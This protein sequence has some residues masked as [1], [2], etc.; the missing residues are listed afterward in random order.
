MS[1][2]RIDRLPPK[3]DRQAQ[4][5]R[6]VRRVVTRCRVG[7]ERLEARQLMAVGTLSEYPIPW[8]PSIPSNI[9]GAS[10]GSLWF[11]DIDAPLDPVS[12]E[13]ATVGRVTTA[14]VVSKSALLRLEYTNDITL[15]PDQALWVTDIGTKKIIA[16]IDPT[17]D[18]AT[19]RSSSITEYENFPDPNLLHFPYALT[20]GPG[21]DHRYLWFAD[22]ATDPIDGYV[23][24]SIGRIDVNAGPDQVIQE[25]SL[26][27]GRYV[28]NESLIPGPPGDDGLYFVERSLGVPGVHYQIGRI[29]LDGTFTDY[30]EIDPDGPALNDIGGIALGPDDAIYYTQQSSGRIGRLDLATRVVDGDFFTVP[31]AVNRP[32]TPYTENFAQGITLSH[33]GTLYFVIPADNT[34]GRLTIGPGGTVGGFFEYPKVQGFVHSVTSDLQGN[35]WFIED[36]P[37]QIGT[38]T[39]PTTPLQA[40]PAPIL[41]AAGQALSNV[42]VALFTDPAGPISGGQYRAS[43]DWGDGSAI[44]ANTTFMATG[45][46]S[47]FVVRGSHT[48]ASPGH[49]TPVVTITDLAS[50]RTAAALDTAAIAIA[51]PAPG[52][53]GTFGA[54]AGTP[55][56]GLLASFQV[57]TTNPGGYEA[58]VDWGDGSPVGGATIA[59][60]FPPA[61]GGPI[62]EVAA[63]HTFAVG[64]SYQGS[65]TVR[66]SAGVL[67]VFPI[68]STVSGLVPLPLLDYLVTPTAGTPF[69]PLPVATIVPAPTAI[70]LTSVAITLPPPPDARFYSAT[71]DWGDGTGPAPATVADATNGLDIRSSGHTYSSPGRYTATFTL[72]AA[73]TPSLVVG[74]V[75]IGV[76]G[77]SPKAFDIFAT[78]GTPLPPES[79][80]TLTPVILPGG[81]MAPDP[82][83]YSATVDWGD[84]S[85]AGPATIT[86][87]SSGLQ[88]QVGGHTYAAPG[89]YTIRYTVGDPGNPGL[90]RGTI[91]ASVHGLTA[92]PIPVNG[93]VDRPLV[94]TPDGS[95]GLPVP[96]LTIGDLSPG[97]GDYSATI[98]WGDGSP[99]GTGTIVPD[100]FGASTVKGPSHIYAGPGLFRINVLIGTTGQPELASFS[101]SAAI[102]ETPISITGVLDPSSDS[103]VSDTD[104]ITNVVTPTIIGTTAP[105]ATVQLYA[106][107]T[108]DPTGYPILI[109]QG[110]ADASGHYSITTIKLANGSYTLDA[111]ATGKGGSVSAIAQIESLAHP[112]VIDTVVPKIVGFGVTN[113]LKGLFQVAYQDDRS[114]LVTPELVNGANY[115]V[116]RPVPK[117]TPG[118]R[119]LVSSLSATPE[120]SPTRPVIV[121]ASVFNGHYL[122]IRDGQFFF[123]INAA[124]ITDVAGN[125]LDGE[126]YGKFPTGDGHHGGNFEAEVIIKGYTPSGPIPFTTANPSQPGVAAVSPT[127]LAPKLKKPG[128]NAPPTS[129]PGRSTGT[130]LASTT[131]THAK[132]KTKARPIV[133]RHAK[134]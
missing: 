77:F 78:A 62:D 68:R 54:T 30:P 10:D 57:G 71:I 58:T 79:L 15:G 89:S 27:P 59:T 112:L 44:D 55:A 33:D 128:L 131:A 73:G 85:P 116:Q 106:H 32:W 104:G 41:G 94:V 124:G 125:A 45:S 81:P 100:S 129:M 40:Q 132:A 24:N 8:T 76:A 5:T 88:L 102:I 65:V 23:T 70:P 35:P 107:L 114:G 31:S 37:A 51:S 92:I 84:G 130:K 49:F 90:V 14:G 2:P 13:Q 19:G 7:L 111:L 93:V 108:I 75:Q 80:A 38:F 46:A 113:T 126:F 109:G 86:G 12:G 26:P 4:A 83:Y 3:R 120:L 110:L 66:D 6:P 60:L 29:A 21:I 1:H 9:A 69:G 98:D 101:T 97:R 43:I 53:V 64:G 99:T 11:T 91:A 118:Q 20:R 50:P 39:L 117:P 25:F 72:A 82:R 61:G 28:A 18:P 48:Y 47:S 52:D 121:T 96:L 16:R 105:G 95:T 67:T 36:D 22:A 123:T 17:L 74:T 34:I 134:A 63:S 56:S 42:P 133:V 122:T 127:I 119:F 115:H 87:D 103:G